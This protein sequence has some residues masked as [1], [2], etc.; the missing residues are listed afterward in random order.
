MSTEN[1]KLELPELDWI[2]DAVFRKDKDDETVDPKMWK[3]KN[4]AVV[5]F[6]KDEKVG[7]DLICVALPNDEDCYDNPVGYTPT[8][9]AENEPLIERSLSR[10]MMLEDEGFLP[11]VG[12]R[13]ASD[14]YLVIWDKVE[15]TK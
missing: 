8:E 12:K 10:L 13:I 6:Q 7:D 5:F 2:L 11:G 15:E 9:L 1:E 14:T 4:T 3:G